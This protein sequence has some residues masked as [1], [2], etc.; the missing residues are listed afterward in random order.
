MCG[1]PLGKTLENLGIFTVKAQRLSRLSGICSISIRDSPGSFYRIMETLWKV[2]EKSTNFLNPFLSVPPNDCISCVML[3]NPRATSSQ[4]IEN[5]KSLQ[6][7]YTECCEVKH[8]PNLIFK[9][10]RSLFCITNKQKHYLH[11]PLVLCP[12]SNY[13]FLHKYEKA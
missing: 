6:A 3:K 12:V 4:P 10:E 8:N 5:K 2:S 1:D 9:L 13:P 7:H 11:R